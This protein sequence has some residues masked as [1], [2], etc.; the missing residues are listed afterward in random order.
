MDAPCRSHWKKPSAVAIGTLAVLL[1]IVAIRAV[2]L[3]SESGRTY[4][5]GVE[6]GQHNLTLQTI[7]RLA[8]SL[9]VPVCDFS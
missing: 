1:S 5:T 9:G 3:S 6:A 4:V 8:D 7:S 2:W